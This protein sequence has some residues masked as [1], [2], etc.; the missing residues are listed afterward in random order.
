MP[1]R[2]NNDIEAN[3]GCAPVPLTPERI[4]SLQQSDPRWKK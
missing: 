1:E 2:G 3:N 4:A